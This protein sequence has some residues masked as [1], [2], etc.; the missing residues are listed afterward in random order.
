MGNSNEMGTQT[1]DN[2]MERIVRTES[3]IWACILR[4]VERRG[5]INGSNPLLGG[6][7]E[8]KN[9]ETPVDPYHNF[10]E[11]EEYTERDGEDDEED[12]V[13]Q[14]FEEFKGYNESEHEEDDESSP[15]Y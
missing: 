6:Q 1:A 4:A 13:D 2:I 14:Y 3:N 7:D 10:E 11:S 9:D 15:D 5:G 12:D 8:D